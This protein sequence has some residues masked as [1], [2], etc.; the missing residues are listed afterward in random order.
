MHAVYFLTDSGSRRSY[1]GYTTDVFR[2]FRTHY[3]KLKAAAKYTKSFVGEAQLV[4]YITGFPTKHLAMSY[5][6]HAKRLRTTTRIDQSHH[7]P[8]LK[9]FLDPLGFPKFASCVS[10]LEIIIK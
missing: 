8:R 4:A 3:L 1:I 2:R 5:E 9:N 10:E 7:H 6:W